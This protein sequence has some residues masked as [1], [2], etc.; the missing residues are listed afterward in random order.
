MD[1]IYKIEVSL[2]PNNELNNSKP[3]FWVLKSNTGNDWCTENAGWESTP[4]EAWE[5][6]YNFYRRYKLVR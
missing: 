1:K 3:F 2:F 4:E 5:A 6:A